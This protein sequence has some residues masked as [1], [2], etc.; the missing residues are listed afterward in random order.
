[1]LYKTSGKDFIPTQLYIDLILMIKNVF[2]SVAKAKVDTPHACFF[3]VQLGT[4]RLEIHFGILRT[5][6]GNDCNLDV[7]QIS[8]RT[9]GL[10]EIADILSQRPDWD[11]G[12]RRMQI[13]TLSKQTGDVPEHADHLSPQYLRGNYAVA[14]VTLLTCWRRG[15]ARAEADYPPAIEILKEADKDGSLEEDDLDESSERFALNANTDPADAAPETSQNADPADP[16][17]ETNH[18]MP[19]PRS[20][21]RL[22]TP[23]YLPTAS[24]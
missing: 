5:V 7:L 9:G 10:V 18:R 8:D 16:A 4:D 1:M 3:I 22:L 12:P 23:P 20:P 17:P 14:N 19:H 13:P 11:Q 21:Q 15:R 6:V 24:W 2:F